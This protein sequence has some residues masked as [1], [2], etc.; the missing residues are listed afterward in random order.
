[1]RRLVTA[2]LSVALALCLV[3]ALAGCG[4]TVAGTYVAESDDPE[5]ETAE[6][7]MQDDG[8]FELSAEIVGTEETVT[9]TGSW[10][11]DGDVITL[12]AEGLNETETGMVDESDGTR[13][14]FDEVTWVRQ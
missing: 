13:L 3:A 14:V 4:T 12:E 2:A 5:F 11:L 6:L 7:V 10:T 8:T 9:V 1:M